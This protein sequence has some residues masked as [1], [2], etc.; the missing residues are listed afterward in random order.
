MTSL[1]K[2]FAGS[3]LHNLLQFESVFTAQDHH[4]VKN[5]LN[6]TLHM[7]DGV[8]GPLRPRNRV[9][10][11]LHNDVATDNLVRPRTLVTNFNP[12]PNSKPKIIQSE[13]KEPNPV[14]SK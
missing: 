8:F 13:S 5:K 12:S 2:P 6:D 9:Y 1:V 11:L 7:R 10:E 14:S 3:N 4:L